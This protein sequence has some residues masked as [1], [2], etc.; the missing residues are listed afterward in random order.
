MLALMLMLIML[1]RSYIGA[2]AANDAHLLLRGN[3]RG[4]GANLGVRPSLGDLEGFRSCSDDDTS[5]TNT[6]APA[7]S[8]ANLHLRL[9]APVSAPATG[10]DTHTRTCTRISPP[11]VDHEG[12]W[13][14]AGA[15]RWTTR[16][17]RRVP[18]SVAVQIYRMCPLFEQHPNWR[19]R[20][21]RGS[22]RWGE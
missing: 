8:L 1:M 21:G 22:A 4:S 13:R 19:Q 7:Q 18:S 14:R 2:S 3:A 12:F 9:L 5:R 20:T 15:P 10:I 16:G 17:P 11:W 6:H